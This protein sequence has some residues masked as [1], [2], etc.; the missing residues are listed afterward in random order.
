MFVKVTTIIIK[1]RTIPFPSY[2]KELNINNKLG[3]KTL[4]QKSK[5]GQ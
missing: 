2:S 5:I 4:T 3:R 1:D